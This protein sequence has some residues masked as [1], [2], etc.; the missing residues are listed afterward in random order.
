MNIH[1]VKATWTSDKTIVND[2]YRFSKI[3]NEW[4]LQINRRAN[5]EIV[6]EETND[7]NLKWCSRFS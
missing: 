2:R 4:F 5:N 7:I 1:N 3:N 6:K